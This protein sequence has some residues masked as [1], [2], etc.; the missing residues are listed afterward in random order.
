M[1]PYLAKLVDVNGSKASFLYDWQRDD[2][3]VVEGDLYVFFPNHVGVGTR[4]NI[5]TGKTEVTSSPSDDVVRIFHT[6]FDPYGRVINN[7]LVSSDS[8]T[9]LN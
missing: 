7:Y 9:P 3:F 4:M 2:K 8:V 5:E 1:G 6:A